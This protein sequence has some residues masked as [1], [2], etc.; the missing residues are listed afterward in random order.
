MVFQGFKVPHMKKGMLTMDRHETQE[1]PTLVARCGKLGGSLATLL[2]CCQDYQGSVFFIT[3]KDS[4]SVH[5]FWGVRG[6]N[7]IL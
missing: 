1:T 2:R 6:M 7:T 5:G 3:L 4:R